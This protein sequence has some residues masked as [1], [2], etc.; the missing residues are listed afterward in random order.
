[1][2]CDGV[3]RNCNHNFKRERLY[4]GKRLDNGEWFYGNEIWSPW[5]GDASFVTLSDHEHIANVDPETV[6]EFT[7]AST[8][9]GN[10]I[11]E[12]DIIDIPGWVVAYSDGMN[13]CYGL[14]V[15]WYI[16]RDNWESCMELQE[17]DRFVVIGN[18][19]DNPEMIRKELT[20]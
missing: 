18:I 11:F 17:T 5:L 2:N 6:C 9:N 4:R 8:G 14:Q 12:G 19:Y 16:Q 7:G 15:G 20:K 13:C 10:K 1:M 3:C